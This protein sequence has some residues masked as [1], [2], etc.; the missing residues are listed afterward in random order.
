MEE[1]QYD[2]LRMDGLTFNRTAVEVGP[3][4]FV[5]EKNAC[6]E[7]DR[8][9]NLLLSTYEVPIEEAFIEEEQ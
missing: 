8:R 5:V 2:V 4:L 9:S 1:V 3:S 7:K 6:E